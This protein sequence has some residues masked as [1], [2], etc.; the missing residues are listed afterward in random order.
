MTQFL[1]DGTMQDAGALDT[2]ARSVLGVAMFGVGNTATQ[3]YIDFD[4]DPSLANQAV[5]ESILTGHGALTLAVDQAAISADGVD[6]AVVS[7][8]GVDG[9]DS[10]DYTIKKDGVVWATGTDGAA[11]FQISFSTDEAGT[12]TFEVKKVGTY[13]TGFVTVVAS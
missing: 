10:F 1:R 12:Y 9:V 6:V 7:W 11:P 8:S 13:E 2:L 5:A 3:L 4:G